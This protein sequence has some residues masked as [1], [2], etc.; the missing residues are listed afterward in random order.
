VQFGK[1]FGT[2]VLNLWEPA[3]SRGTVFCIHGFEGNGRDFDF[4][5]SHLVQ[6]DFTVVCPDMIGRGRSTFFGKATSYD[7]DAYSNCLR[8]LTK[9]GAKKNYIVGTS[10]GG[11]A[12]IR[13][14]VASRASVDKL[15]LNDVSLRG[16]PAADRLMNSIRLEAS[17]QFDRAEDAR[18][19]VRRSRA[20][21][22][23]I[24]EDLW[25]GYLANRIRHA[26]GKYR[27]A[28]DPMIIPAARQERYDLVSVLSGLDTETALLFGEHS[29]FYDAAAVAPLL[30]NP[31]RFSCVS[32]PGASHPVS[33]MMP[34]QAEL[35]ARLLE[36]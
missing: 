19:Y 31:A 21:L 22:G 16:G 25:P 27:M 23:N 1:T 12:A 2:V 14:L 36:S 28:Y 11:Q 34:D 13:F 15:I 3:Q 24:S 18:T 7:N 35:V 33:L 32:V 8:A 30:K 9:F 20:F 6:R 4:L 17:L 10:W 26:G 29:Q 5:A